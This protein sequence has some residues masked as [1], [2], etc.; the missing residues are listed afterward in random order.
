MYPGGPRAAYYCSKHL[1]ESDGE[2]YWFL[3]PR[4]LIWGFS[5]L[6]KHQR[7]V[8]TDSNDVVSL[9]LFAASV[10]SV[11]SVSSGLRDEEGARARDHSFPA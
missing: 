11:R 5:S 3:R 7:G 2:K 10:S 1:R 6:G 9:D 4:A 8:G